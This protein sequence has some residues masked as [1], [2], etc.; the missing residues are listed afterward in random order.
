M[1]NIDNTNNS[2]NLTPILCDP[3]YTLAA[4]NTYIRGIHADFNTLECNIL[5]LAIMQITQKDKTIPICSW[6]IP[7]LAAALHIDKSNIYRQLEKLTD[8]FMNKSVKIPPAGKTEKDISEKTYKKIHYVSTCEVN[9]GVLTLKL[10]E[11]ST[12]YLIDL[13]KN[14]TVIKWKYLNALQTPISKSFF[15]TLT[16]YE[17]MG[18]V[19]FSIE[20]LRAHF[21]GT[22]KYRLT[23]DF[24]KRIIEPSVSAIKKNTCYKNLSYK[25]TKKDRKIVSITFSFGEKVFDSDNELTSAEQKSEEQETEINNGALVSETKNTEKTKPGSADRNPEAEKNIEDLKEKMW[26]S[27]ISL[28]FKDCPEEQVALDCLVKKIEELYRK[29]NKKVIVGGKSVDRKSVQQELL[30]AKELFAPTITVIN[31]YIARAENIDHPGGYL[32]TSLINEIRKPQ[33]TDDDWD[34]I[35]PLANQQ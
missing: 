15:W 2:Q 16:S 17:N 13:K 11:E 6:S 20:W 33:E 35:L 7:D 9:N 28:E 3:E 31:E 18:E 21:D 14:Y 22:K 25:T 5:Y 30:N 8:Q 34:D 26:L 24:I 27:V 32:F 23:A 12:P 1:S 29:K 19:T 10:S 4:A